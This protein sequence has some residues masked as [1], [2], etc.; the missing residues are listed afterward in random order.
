MNIFGVHPVEELIRTAPEQVQQVR[1]SRWDA[2][3][4]A[5]VR[6]LCDAAGI[7]RVSVS[8][9]ELDEEIERGNHQGVV[10]DTKEFPYANLETVLKGLG[11]RTTA[12]ILVLDQVQDPQNLGAILR[13]AAA[14]SVDAVVI[15]KDRAATIT[16]T[17]VRASSGLAYR[18]PVAIATNVA[19]TLSHLKE[20]GFWTVGAFMDGEFTTWDMDFK[21]KTALVMGGESKGIRPLVE[22]GCDFRTRIPMHSGVE[23][24]N[25]GV[26]TAIMLYEIHKQIQQ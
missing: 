7:R 21:M 24:L 17:V 23:S 3:E 20:E 18:V 9:P 4:L 16:S 5:E 2:V 1:S 19:R 15:P 26:A 6:S 10:A 25:V 14:F 22:K 13:A 12:C 11:D 8:K